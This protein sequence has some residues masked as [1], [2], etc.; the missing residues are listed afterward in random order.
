MPARSVVGS[1]PLVLYFPNGTIGWVV[2]LGSKSISIKPFDNWSLVDH[3]SHQ[4]P[5]A[6]IILFSSLRVGYRTNA[7]EFLVFFRS[8]SNGQGPTKKRST[9]SF[10]AEPSHRSEN[11]I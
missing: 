3:L 2:V 10:L 6:L 9:S 4:P 8:P 5:S 7:R 1:Q 11:F